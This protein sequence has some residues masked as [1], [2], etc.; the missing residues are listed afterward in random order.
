MF[1]RFVEVP[2]FGD[3]RTAGQRLADQFARCGLPIDGDPAG[4][5]VATIW[6]DLPATARVLEADFEERV[7]AFMVYRA[8]VIEVDRAVALARATLR[9]PD[10]PR[11][12]WRTAQDLRDLFDALDPPIRDDE[13]DR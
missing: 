6:F 5:S 3:D 8:L 9:R 12:Q 11:Y 10:G 13:D 7:L 2:E 4:A 1:E